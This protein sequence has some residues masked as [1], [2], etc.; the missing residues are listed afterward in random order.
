MIFIIVK[1]KNE[2]QKDLQ[3]LLFHANHEFL[4]LVI[5]N[6][7]FNQAITNTWKWNLFMNLLKSWD[8][9]LESIYE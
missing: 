9:K 2:S 7:L 4:Q 6:F 5:Q 1:A 3:Y 8:D